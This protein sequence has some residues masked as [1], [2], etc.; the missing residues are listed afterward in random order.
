MPAL[1]RSLRCPIS[2]GV[3]LV[4][5]SLNG[6]SDI[7]SRMLARGHQPSPFLAV[8][9]GDGRIRLIRTTQFDAALGLVRNEY[10]AVS[11][12]YAIETEPTP[13]VR[14]L[15]RANSS[16]IF[17]RSLGMTIGA[18]PNVEVILSPDGVLS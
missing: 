8:T 6:M 11:E 18:L 15:Y 10:G 7:L 4:S 12:A 17:A 1:N 9:L 5:T 2:F 16:A 3:E 14:L 13:R